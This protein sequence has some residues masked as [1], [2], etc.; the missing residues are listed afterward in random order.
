L[1][2]QS[3]GRALRPAA[4]EAPPRQLDCRACGLVRPKSRRRAPDIPANP[5][6]WS[7]LLNNVSDEGELAGR[8]T[9]SADDGSDEGGV[10]PSDQAQVEE[11][12]RGGDHPVNIAGVEELPAPS[13]RSPTLAGKHREV[14][15]RGKAAD[16]HIAVVVRLL[17]SSA[18]NAGDEH[19]GRH[20]EDEEGNG[21]GADTGRSDLLDGG[22]RGGR[23]RSI[24]QQMPSRH[25]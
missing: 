12:E 16:E 1:I 8:L 5:T 17:G 9:V 24:F 11:E 25:G 7:A 13:N 22:A 10:R 20:R 14:G 21:Q 19:D 23:E 2:D 6:A 18:A 3:K 4:A 15:H